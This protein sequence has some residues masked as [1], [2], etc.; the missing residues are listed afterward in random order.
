MDDQKFNCYKALDMDQLRRFA[1]MARE[2]RT[3]NVTGEDD[4]IAASVAKMDKIGDLMRIVLK[5]ESATRFIELL[6]PTDEKRED[7]DFEPIDPFQ[8]LDIVK[9]L[10]EIYTQRPTEPSSTSSGGSANGET[11]TSSTAGALPTASSFVHLTPRT[12]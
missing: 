5:K 12:D 10:L 8:L 1:N 9:W 2:L 7:D 3:D 6:N 11:G 4:Q